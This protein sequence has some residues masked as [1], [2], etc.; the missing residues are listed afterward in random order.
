MNSDAIGGYLG[1]ELPPHGQEW[2]PDA[3]RFQSARAA[4]LAMLR[5]HTPAAVWVPWYLC[6]SMLEPLQTAGSTVKRYA[7]R[8][9]LACPEIPLGDGEWLLYVNYF[10]VC[11]RHV[12]DVLARYPREQVV[13]D[14]AHA[15][16][17]PVRDNLATIY[18][19][20]KFVGVPDGGY[21]VTQ[22]PVALPEEIDDGAANRCRHLLARLAT[23]AEAGYAD[24]ATAESSLQ[25]QEPRRMSPLTRHLLA[26]IDYPSVRA[27]RAANFR[28]LH[29]RLGSRN[30][31][32]L[33]ADPECAPLCYPFGSAPRGLREAWRA[34]RIYSPTYW[35][36]LGPTA[37][38]PAFEQSLPETTLFIPCDQRLSPERLEPLVQHLL[39]QLDP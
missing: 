15:F 11:D 31:L 16:F 9:D 2:Y 36:N 34:R 17:S 28:Y 6:D 25:W 18:S 24:Y 12:D 29:T 10:G 5:S 30:P 13:I 32:S 22:A 27:R 8:E 1:L 4:F 7:L 14:N 37:G 19:P 20:R 23:G 33:A 21:L 35:P 38:M 39:E 26:S 3:L